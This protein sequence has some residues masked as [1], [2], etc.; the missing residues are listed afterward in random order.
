M[1]RILLEGCR[2][3]PLASYLKALGTLRLVS[4]QADPSARGHWSTDGFVL[5]TVLS[6]QELLDFFLGSYTPTSIVSP[7]NGGSGFAPKDNTEALEVIATSTDPRLAVYRNV[8]NQVKLIGH[9]DSKGSIEKA[10]YLTGLRNTLPDDALPWLDAAAVLFAEGL[11]QSVRFP[12]LLGT[13]GNDGR[14]DFSNNYMQRLCDALGLRPAKKGMAD[15]PSLWLS[16]ALF[17]NGE[18]PLMDAAIG[19]FD[20]GGAGGSNSAPQGKGKSLVNPWDFVLMLEGAMVFSGAAVRRRGEVAATVSIP[21]WFSASPVGYGSAANEN[22]RGEIWAPIWEQPTNLRGVES[23]FAEGRV[24]WDGYQ[25]RTGLDAARAIATLQHDRR[26][27]SFVRYV[28]AERFGLSNIASPV[29][30]ITM[31]T[32][33]RKDVDVTLSLDRWLQRVKRFAPNGVQSVARLAEQAIYNLATASEKDQR[34]AYVLSVLENISL[35]ELA[36]AKSSALRNEVQPISRLYASEWKPGLLAVLEREL[37]ARIAWSLASGRDDWSRIQPRKI[38]EFVFPVDS[39]GG[40]SKAPIV[41][42]FGVAPIAKVLSEIAARREWS[43]NDR[44]GNRNEDSQ[45]RK[46]CRIAFERGG[47][48]HPNDAVRF[49]SGDFDDEYFYRCLI[50]FSILDF[51]QRSGG[52]SAGDILSE[53]G[54]VSNIRD[55]GSPFDLGV[56]SMVAAVL[57]HAGPIDPAIPSP[58]SLARQLATNSS[59][60]IGALRQSIQIEHF[61]P[62]LP[63]DAAHTEWLAASLLLAPDIRAEHAQQRCNPFLMRAG[64]PSAAVQ[65][66]VGDPKR[67]D[68]DDSQ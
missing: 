20:P 14:F 6:Q 44:P 50:A 52:E 56:P 12:V 46:G 24:T 3:E 63:E 21:F 61:I 9:Y 67:P 55:V 8:I 26:I 17:G 33:E 13:G 28:I 58:L 49:A 19:Q 38:R 57:M 53:S 7:W 62:N 22:T 30:R 25:A 60:A 40:W 43:I 35:T 2:P 23:L 48:I 34:P 16:Q 37:E 11:G 45:S 1:N 68:S 64:H 42:G 39:K 18:A 65:R 27:S 47:I 59:T 31:P 66:E 4:S 5:T 29:G 15:K 10:D 41:E 36:C 54:R 32:D 51:R